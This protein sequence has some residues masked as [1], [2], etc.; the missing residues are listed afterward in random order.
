MGSRNGKTLFDDIEILIF[1]KFQYARVK[2]LNMAKPRHF[3]VDNTTTR[4]V[5]TAGI[6]FSD[7]CDVNVVLSAIE[8]TFSSLVACGSLSNYAGI[9]GVSIQGVKVN[10]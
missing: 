7:P 5:G 6:E 1:R 9:Q 10:P 2:E 3:I 4:L 8:L